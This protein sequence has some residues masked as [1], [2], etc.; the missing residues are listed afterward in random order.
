MDGTIIDVEVAAVPFNYHGEDGALVFVRDITERKQARQALLAS[1]ERFRSIVENT[2]AGYFF[3]DLSGTILDANAAWAKMYGYERCEDVIG[4]N[5]ISM[6]HDDDIEQA[7]VIIKGILHNQKQYLSGIFS[8]K[9]KDGRIGDHTYSARAVR[10]EGKAI[11]VEG[12]IIDTT[13]LR[14]AQDALRASEQK[15]RSLFETMAEG[16]ALHELIY[17]EKNQ[18]VDYRILDINSAYEKQTGV[19]AQRAKGRPAKIVYQGMDSPYLDVFAQVAL[20]GEPYYF[21]PF[22]APLNRHFSVSVVSPA[23]GQ[24]AT[25]FQDITMRKRMENA[26][27][28]EK[29]RLLV[30]LRSIGDGVITTD[31]E[32]R[33]VL[34]NKVAEAL[35]GW[36]NAEAANKPLADVFHIIHEETGNRCENPVRKVLESGQIIG[37]A[38]HTALISRDGTQRVIADSAAPIRDGENKIIGVVL[39]FR[40]TTGKKRMDEAIRNAEKLEAIGILAGGISHDFNNL[41]A[42]IFGY[43]EMIK[44]DAENGD[45]SRIQED[46]VKAMSTYDRAKQVTAQLLTFSKGGMPI[47]KIHHLD[48]LIRDSVTFVTGRVRCE[49]LIPHSRGRL[50]MQL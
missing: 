16:V 49:R 40:D 18:P 20:T 32:G 33:I 12:F 27:A 13:E 19:P 24:F 3:V 1:E 36:S 44:N 25:V 31:I 21:E 29:E 5:F 6:Q 35:T 4:R 17:D 30:T 15:F 14:Q 50:A 10:K 7:R 45:L 48:R 43:L 37:L 28:E 47:R 8:R 42:G 9:I 41:L 39:V 46:V 22:F 23:T 11:G 26:L 34:M 38:N 2:E